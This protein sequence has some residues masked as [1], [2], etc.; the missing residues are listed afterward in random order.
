[1]AA[2]PCRW[3]YVGGV[4]RNGSGAA[5]GLEEGLA[6]RGLRSSIAVSLAGGSARSAREVLD[7]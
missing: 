4:V 3:V 2:G 6:L 7:G 5:E 1:M